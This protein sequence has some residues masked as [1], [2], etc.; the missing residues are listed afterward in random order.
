M[1]TPGGAVVEKPK[2]TIRFIED[3]TEAEVAQQ[4]GAIPAGLQNLGNTCYMNSTIQVLRSIPEL[5]SQLTTYKPAPPAPSASESLSLTSLLGA[6]GSGDDLTRSLRDLLRQMSLTQEPFAPQMFLMALRT[7]F[8]QFAQR[9]REGHGYAQQDAEEAWSQILSKIR[10]QLK[11]K[12]TVDGSETHSSFV[13]KYM[14][15]S[16][17]SELKCDEG[18]MEEPVISNE[19]FF[20]LNCHIDTDTS[21]L[22]DG[23]ASGL[24]EKLEKKSELLDRDAVYT[25]KSRLT[26]LPKYLTVHFMRFDWR[27]DTNKKAKIMRKVTFPQELDAV[28]FCSE[29]LQKILVPIRNKFRDVRNLELDD[30]RAKK[31]QK[32]KAD[33]EE[34]PEAGPSSSK[35]TKNEKG[36]GKKKTEAEDVEMKD[37]VYK[38][39]VELDA[40]RTAGILEAKKELWALVDPKTAADETANSTGLYELRGIITHQGP[41][42]DSGHYTAFVKKSG[43]KDPKTGKEGKED[44]KWWWFN[45]EKVSEFEADSIDTLAGGGKFS[46]AYPIFRSL[47]SR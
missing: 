7:Q 17:T 26:K 33:G 14:A 29:D 44:G 18:D 22:R 46:L 15:G 38:T 24:V 27:K 39:D 30:E 8:P 4:D 32:R 10:G 28:E 13:D 6:S 36:K 43:R 31:R 45:D 9:S 12:E 21:H 40:E 2:E 47:I 37:V 3:M 11:I 16:L 42:A 23:L 25:K 5:Q 20:K 19:A 41:T 35:A 34:P 1:G